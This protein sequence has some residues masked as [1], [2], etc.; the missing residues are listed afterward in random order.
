MLIEKPSK[1]KQELYVSDSVKELLACLPDEVT[2]PDMTALMEMDLDKIDAGTLSLDDYMHGQEEYIR[3]IINLESRFTVIPKNND[4]LTCPVCGVGKLFPREGK[5]GKFWSCGN[6]KNGCNAT[7]KDYKG[8]PVIE[9]CPVCGKGLLQKRHGKNGDFWS[10]SEYRNSGCKAAFSDVKGKPV[11]VLCPDCK[12]SYLIKRS[13]KMVIFTDAIIILIV[14]RHLKAA[15]M[16]CQ[17]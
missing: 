15:K 9:K 6:Y 7:F 14:K 11:I 12:K 17:Y 5:Y 2:Y 1:K 10:C 4:Y 3:R 13:G 8:A 16:V